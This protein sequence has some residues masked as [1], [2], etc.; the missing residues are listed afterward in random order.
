M[1]DASKAGL[2]P[3]AVQLDLLRAGLLD[4]MPA[5]RSSLLHH[6]AECDVCR[7]RMARWKRIMGIGLPRTEELSRQLR[8]RRRLA[9]DGYR[10]G[11]TRPDST[12]RMTVAA[13]AAALVLALGTA[14]GLQLRELRQGPAPLP[15]VAQADQVPDLYSHID[16]YLWVSREGVP[17]TSH[18]NPS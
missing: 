9:L 2:H 10:S 12:A 8:E 6:I 3:D 4:D 13:I 11:R 16:F 1:N 14:F 5:E 17:K 15:D 7:L 18:D